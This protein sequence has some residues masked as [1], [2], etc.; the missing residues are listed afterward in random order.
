MVRY[1]VFSR[2]MSSSVSNFSASR[3]IETP[4]VDQ[5]FIRTA[6]TN[7]IPSSVIITSS[8]SYRH[9]CSPGFFVVTPIAVSELW[10][11][12][13]KVWSEP[14]A[15]FWSR[16]HLAPSS[17][18]KIVRCFSANRPSYTQHDLLSLKSASTN[19]Q[20]R[21]PIAIWHS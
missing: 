18:A 5:R 20:K 12:H 15:T 3:M 2:F 10:T 4:H 14:W 1:F 13:E 19:S 17:G 16:Q 21:C 9:K 11:S 7:A 6:T 8:T